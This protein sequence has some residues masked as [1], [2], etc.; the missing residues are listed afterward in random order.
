MLVMFFTSVNSQE[1]Y[2]KLTEATFHCPTIIIN[3]NIISNNY[4]IKNN[5]ELIT[6]ISVMKDTP[7]KKNHKLYNLSENGIIFIE[8]DEKIKT[9]SQYDLN[10]F[11]GL[12]K[13]REVYVNGYLLEDSEYKIAT[14]SIIEIEFVKPNPSNKLVNKS[15][16][17]WTI[18]NK[19]RQE[20]CKI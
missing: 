7:D 14:E 3:D 18:T 6:K 13:K 11:F 15:I 8:F 2:F 10:I 12:D 20:G 5:K 4:F 9:T 1:K 17:V 19:Q 16:N